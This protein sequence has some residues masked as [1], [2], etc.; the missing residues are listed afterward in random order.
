MRDRM[1]QCAA[2]KLHKDPGQEGLLSTCGHR[3]RET[4][5]LLENGATWPKGPDESTVDLAVHWPEPP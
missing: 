2:G 4:R 5:A 1:A 3:T